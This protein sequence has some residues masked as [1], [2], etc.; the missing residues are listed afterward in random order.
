MVQI[1][2]EQPSF[3]SRILRGVGAGA[4]YGA[5][6]G[7]SLHEKNLQKKENEKERSF[8]EKLLDKQIKSRQDLETYKNSLKPGANPLSIYDIDKFIGLEP[9]LKDITSA[10]DKENIRKRAVELEAKTGNREQA[11]SQA[12]Q[13]Y[14]GGGQQQPEENPLIQQQIPQQAQEAPPIN[15]EEGF[16]AAVTKG[17]QSSVF[18]RASAIAQGIP[19]DEYEKSIQLQDGGFF[20]RLTQGISRFAAESPLYGAGASIGGSVGAAG[21]PVGAAVGGAAGSMALPAMVDTALE[22]Y[23][24]YL[25]QGG[26]ASFEDF[27][28]AV[29]DTLQTGVRAGAEGVIFGAVSKAMPFIKNLPGFESLFGKSKIGQKVAESGLQ[30][31]AITGA[32][33]LSKMEVPTTEEVV[34]TFAQVLGLNLLH[35]FPKD[36]ANKIID[37]ISKT[38]DPVGVA[39][40]VQSQILDKGIDP[41]DTKAISKVIADVTKTYEGKTKEVA[42]EKLAEVPETPKLVE[43][44]KSEARKTAEV[45]AERPVE[46]TFESE[47]KKEEKSEKPLTK[48]ESEKRESAKKE[49]QDLTDKIESIEGDIAYLSQKAA[50]PKAKDTKALEGAIKLKNQER[51]ELINERDALKRRAEGKAEPFT[52]EGLEEPIRK[53]MAELKVFA[54]EPESHTAKEWEEMYKRDQ[55]Y[56][57]EFDKLATKEQLP[58]AKYKDRIIKILETYQKAY[59]NHNDFLRSEIGRIEKEMEGL[60][61]RTKR[62]KDLAPQ[63]AQ[64]KR[65]HTLL[66]KNFL[67]NQSKIALQKDK[68]AQLYQLKKPGSAL[69]KQHLKNLRKDIVD[70]QRDF[71]KQKR[72]LDALDKKTEKAAKEQLEH[73]DK[74][75]EDYVKKPSEPKLENLIEEAGLSKQEVSEAKAQGKEIAKELEKTIKEKG[76]L[77]EFLD[78]LKEKAPEFLKEKGKD[79]VSSA[80][81]GIIFAE[82]QDAIEKLTG[83]KVPLVL[84]GQATNNL[85]KGSATVGFSAL[86][87][88]GKNQYFIGQEKEAYKKLKTPREKLAFRKRLKEEEYTKKE[89]DII[90]GTSQK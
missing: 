81:K 38:G 63:L 70:I 15:T 51:Q 12:L 20:K 19:Y 32:K 87:R 6:L 80:I 22:H 86:W 72:E 8:R 55:K 26:D 65:H 7:L 11:I 21:G 61:K 57:D 37:K 68:L 3:A 23:H 66:A 60:S 41:S 64:L 47:K 24:Q 42:K 31:A 35:I 79:L 76:S 25:S 59:K 71:I 18:G 16:G 28:N 77:K 58:P 82:V 90:S 56:I 29:N 33:S 62:Y 48:K 46:E 14:L 50:D 36:K 44:G 89:I 88:W 52:E 85:L 27:V 10:A 34:D 13:E 30:T 83:F 74:L 40:D 2:E 4:S 69:V 84:I 45:L 43:T 17:I 1:I 54:E 39:T 67:I 78:K 5:E 75:V 73:V 53:H 9:N 49:A